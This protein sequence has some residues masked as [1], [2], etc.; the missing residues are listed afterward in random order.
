M[1]FGKM[2]IKKDSF[3]KYSSKMVNR[4]LISSVGEYQDYINYFHKLW[5]VD[6]TLWFRGVSNSKY[7]L[8]PSIYRN[9]VWAYDADLAK[10]MVNSFIHR[11]RGYLPNAHLIG[12]WEW[13]QI[14]QHHNMPTRLLDWTSGYSIALYFACRTAIAEM[15]TT[16]SVWILNPYYLNEL[17][18]KQMVIFYTDKLTRDSEDSVVDEYLFDNHELP[19]YPIAII[20]PYV[21]ERM[22]SQ[23]SCFTVHGKVKFGFEEL[24]KKNKS[25]ELVQLQISKKAAYGIKHDLVESGITEGTLFPDLEGLARE[26]RFDFEMDLY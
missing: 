16:P 14:I 1:L 4:E 13:Y 17:S 11:A 22:S 3:I 8:V 9:K 7:K 23:K 19:K 5:G 26:L 18:K 20:P 12:K 15:S 24:Y 2:I 10:D 21:N 25:F 6:T